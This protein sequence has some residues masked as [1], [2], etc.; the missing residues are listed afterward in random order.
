MSVVSVVCCQIELSA[1]GRSLVQRS[2]TE[3]ATGTVEKSRSVFYSKTNLNYSTGQ[4]CSCKSN[5]LG[6]AKGIWH[7]HHS[8]QIHH[9]HH[10]HHIISIL[11]TYRLLYICCIHISRSQ[12]PRGL[13]SGSTA[14]RLLGLVKVKQSRYRPGV[15]QRVPGS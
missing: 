1:S 10:H 8:H 6:N 4:S 11:Y 2:L 3:C 5:L 15:V 13:R 14:T 9:H 12:C 7:Y